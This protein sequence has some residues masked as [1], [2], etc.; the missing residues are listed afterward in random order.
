MYFFT[1]TAWLCTNLVWNP[2]PVVKLLWVLHCSSSHSPAN[3]PTTPTSLC[4]SPMWYKYS[5]EC[6][7]RGLLKVYFINLIPP[8]WEHVKGTWAKMGAQIP[9]WY[10]Y[11][12][13]CLIRGLLKGYFINL[14][15]PLSEHV[16]GTW[17]K[18]GAHIPLFLVDQLSPLW[19]LVRNFLNSIENVQI[20]N[21]RSYSSGAQYFY[22]YF[23]LIPFSYCL[24]S[25]WS[26]WPVRE[27]SVTAIG[28]I[29]LG[30][31]IPTCAADFSLLNLPK[32]KS[33]GRSKPAT[34]S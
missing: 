30:K 10:K 12:V 14:L 15:P 21:L 24:G 8:L 7:K 20:T 6:L 33:L 16:K 9:L 5:D 1:K 32:G 23:E 13:E 4:T 3:Q 29:L 28:S 31:I 22:Q 17:A 26:C 2:V 11:S 18:M 25:E 19:Q 34:N 27:A